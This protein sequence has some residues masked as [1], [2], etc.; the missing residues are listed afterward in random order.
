MDARLEFLINAFENNGWSNE[1]PVEV[2]GDWW[3]EDIILLI[4]TWRPI[5][6]KL[7]VTLLTDPYYVNKKIVW[8]YA[9]ST[10]LPTGRESIY[11]DHL[12]VND[13]K[14]KALI[15]L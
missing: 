8:E 3:F 13:I 11:I 4:S 6:T 9:I 5:N 7:Y 14:K 10:V 12:P 15:S 2:P 1:G